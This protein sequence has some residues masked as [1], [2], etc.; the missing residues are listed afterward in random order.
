MYV[1]KAA[2][3]HFFLLLVLAGCQPGLTPAPQPS[4]VILAVQITPALHFF[5]ETFYRCAEQ[6]HLALALDTVNPS[7][8]PQ[9]N[10]LHLRLSVSPGW[11]DYA[12]VLLEDELVVV[13]H[14]DNPIAQLD[15]PALQ[16]IFQGKNADWHAWT[17]PEGDDTGQVSDTALATPVATGKTYIAPDPAALREAVAKDPA[18]IGMLPKRWLDASVKLVEVSDQEAGRWQVQ[19]VALSTAEPQGSARDWLLCVQESF[20]G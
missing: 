12:A 10:P 4:P 5:E 1:K 19:M 6:A 20:G 17:Y 14:P 11:Q 15:L 8:P 9:P 3:L 18:A 7:S 13:V 2:A 16:A